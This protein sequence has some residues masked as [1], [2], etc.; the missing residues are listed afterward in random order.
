MASINAR[1]PLIAKIES[2]PDERIAEIGDFV[3]FICMREE[4]SALRRSVA[5]ASGAAALTDLVAGQISMVF[6]T[7]SDLLEQH[8]GGRIKVLAT[9]DKERSPFLPDVPTIRP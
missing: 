8:K 1:A 4:A 3:D 2:L 5:S 9:S 7:T 6:T